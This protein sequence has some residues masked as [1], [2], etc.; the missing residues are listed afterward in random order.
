[1]KPAQREPLPDV[2]RALALIGVVVVNA[3]GYA[4]APSGPV[5]GRA[6]P[7]AE[8][9]AWLAQGLQAFLIQGKAYPALAFLFGWGLAQSL[10]D[11]S[12]HALV[13][14][15]SRLWRLLILGVL[16]GSLIY[17][18]DILTMYALCGFIVLGTVNAPWPSLMRRLKFGLATAVG[19]SLAFFLLLLLLSGEEATEPSFAAVATWPEFLAL[20]FSTYAMVVLAS[21]PLSLPVLCVCMLAGVV[22]SRLRLL[23][24]PRWRYWRRMQVRRWLPA[25]LLANLGYA[26]VL[27]I[28]SNR[29]GERALWVDGQTPLVGVPLSAVF[30]LAFAQAWSEGRLRWAARLAPLGRRT[31]SLY[32]GYSLWC[33]LMLS[34]LFVAWKP[35]TL[36][37][38]ASSLAVWLLAAV[39]AAHSRWRWP[40]EA[41][42]G[43]RT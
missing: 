38:F 3:A 25:L 42:M 32:V 29:E 30:I 6:T 16:H 4:W 27:V 17:F 13:Q 43:R 35:G 5:L 2:L 12:R 36:A 41:W 19:V 10:R 39:L 7:A 34:G 24:H 15:R 23:T 21:A 26:V 40:L 33:M 22:A 14:A 31:L 1:M 20:N 9:L 28:F 11:R 18:G 8:P 37:L